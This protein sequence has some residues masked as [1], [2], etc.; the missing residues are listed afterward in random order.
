VVYYI[1]TSSLR[2]GLITIYT[3]RL[4]DV[5]LLL[6]LYFM[7][8]GFY[9]NLEVF[10]RD[11]FIFLLFFVLLGGITKSAQLPF[12]SWL[13]AAIAA[14]TPVSSLVHSSTLVTAGVYLFVRYYFILSYFLVRKVFCWVRVMTRFMAGLMAYFEKD[15]KKLVAISTLSQLGII[16]L[17]C[18][19]GEFTMCFFHIVSHALFKSLLFLSCGGLI[20]LIGGDQDIR[21]IGGYSF[22]LRMSFLLILISSLNLIGFPFLS[23]FF[24]K[25]M[26]ME[27]GS[28][29]EYNLFIFLLFILSCVF[30]FVYRIKLLH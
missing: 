4:G 8:R 23:G 11:K 14:P 18:S 20:M 27:S 15:L 22:M 25:N 5:F 21:F 19:L 2:S 9:I 7:V 30:S 12:S 29:F 17:I 10:L 3:N 16:M 6:S 1:N 24:S 28:F 26:I 13:P